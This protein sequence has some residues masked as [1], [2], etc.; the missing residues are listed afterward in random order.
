MPK[1]SLP[2][3]WRQYLWRQDLW[4]LLGEGG[5]NFVTILCSLEKNPQFQRG[6]AFQFPIIQHLKRH[7]DK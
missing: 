4:L 5:T 1:A 2:Q 6:S 7:R 3:G